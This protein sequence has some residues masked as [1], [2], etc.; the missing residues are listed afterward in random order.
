MEREDRAL[1]IAALHR[2][3]AADLADKRLT[4]RQTEVRIVDGCYLHQPGRECFISALF[5]DAAA[6]DIKAEIAARGGVG[7]GRRSRVCWRNGGRPVKRRSLPS[8]GLISARHA[9]QT[10]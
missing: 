7:A 9:E 8:C 5:I 10:Q 4:Q 1:S 2:D 3:D 6:D